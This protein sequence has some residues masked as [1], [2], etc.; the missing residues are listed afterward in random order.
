MQIA[1]T[2]P[3]PDIILLDIMMPGMS[4]Y[5]VCEALKKDPATQ[6]IPVIFITAK[7]ATKDEQME[8]ACLKTIAAYLNTDGG[9]LQVGIS[10]P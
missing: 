4:G 7:T 5:E 2:E 8:N 6:T 1:Q 3:Q 9:V 10:R